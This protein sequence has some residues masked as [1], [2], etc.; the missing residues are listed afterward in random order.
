MLAISET[1]D[2]KKAN[3]V[4]VCGTRN[5]EDT[6]DKYIDELDLALSFN[7]PLIC[8]NPDKVVIRKTGELLLCAGAMASYYQKNGGIVY[9]Y[10]KPF[11]ETYQF[12]YDYLTKKN[13]KINKKNILC[14]GD[15]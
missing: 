6:L 2:I 7:L 12:C 11:L 13:I 9:Q 8:A 5:F 4:L 10:G 3:F 1:K 14:V 15:S